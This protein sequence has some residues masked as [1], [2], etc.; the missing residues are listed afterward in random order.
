MLHSLNALLLQTQ[1]CKTKLFPAIWVLD[2]LGKCCQAS[3]GWKHT[4]SQSFVESATASSA[5][6]PPKKSLNPP[7][8]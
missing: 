2:L 3:A 7:K 4:T 8:D 6:L 1:R 5:E